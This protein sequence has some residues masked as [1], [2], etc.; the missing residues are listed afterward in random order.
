[1]FSLISQT[2]CESEALLHDCESCRAL[3]SEAQR[4]RDQHSGLLADARPATTQSYIYIQKTEENGEIRHTFCY[5]LE[6]DRWK[7]LGTRERTVMIPDPPGSCLTSYAEKVSFV[8]EWIFK[9]VDYSP[10]VH[11]GCE[12]HILKFCLSTVFR[13]IELHM[14]YHSLSSILKV[15]S[16][17]S[18][19]MFVTGGCQGNCCRAIRL[20]VAE[21]SHDATDEVWCF[22]PITL[23]CTPAPAMLKP[24]TMHAAVTC[25]GRVYVI[26]GRTRGS[27]EG[28][29]SLLEVRT[30]QP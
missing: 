28:A 20:H 12:Q 30:A 3:V 26:G 5:C 6:T 17:L 19:E 4:R 11:Q 18:L 9:L 22:C 24:R 27:R 29:C 16:H 8:I 25:L 23:T 10:S 13:I 14:F 21:L 1:M 15:P 2:L 7:E